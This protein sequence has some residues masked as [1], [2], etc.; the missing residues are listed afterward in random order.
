MRKGFGIICLVAGMFLLVWG[1]NVA[2]SFKGQLHRI[3]TSS[4][5]NRTT[6]LYAGG[7]VLCAIGVLQIYGGKK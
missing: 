4:T 1:Y 7:A 6:W 2:E 5:N 3:F